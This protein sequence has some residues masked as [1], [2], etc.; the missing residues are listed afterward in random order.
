MMTDLTSYGV[1]DLLNGYKNGDFSPVEVTKSYLDRIDK[2]ND[3]LN[4]FVLVNKDEAIKQAQDAEAAYNSRTSTPS[5]LGIPL[6]HKDLY[7]TAN[8]RSTAGSRVLKDHVPT[9]D[10]TSIALLTSHGAINLG[11]LN[12]H[13][14]AYGPTN[15]QSM[16]G[17]CLNP[18]NTEYF[19]GGSSGGSGAAVAASLCLGATGS[20][21]G[22]SIRIPS[23]CCG[24]TGLKPTYG[25]IS[26][27]GIVPLCW[28]MDHSGPMTRSAKDAALMLQAMAGFDPKDSAS[29]QTVVPDYINSLSG[30]IKGK[31]IGLPNRYFFDQAD[32]SIE[33]SVMQALSVLEGLG[34][35]L[36][37]IDIKYIEHA[38]AAALAIYL[39]EGTAFHDHGFN[40][41]QS[42]YTDQVRGFLELGNFIL[43]KDYIHAQRFRTLL[44]QEMANLLDEVD[45]FATPGLSLTAQKIGQ[46][47]IT[48]RGVDQ[49]VFSAILRNTE[50]FNLTGLPA[51]VMPC[52]FSN[53]GMPQSLQIVGRPFD[54]AGILNVAHAYQEASDWHLKKP[55]L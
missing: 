4:A 11:K 37:P 17:S 50:P 15:E 28:T 24:I 20:D 32:E 31:K 5:L 52:G 13:E 51:I 27:S 29:S 10:A 30:D 33:E 16:F 1:L 40:L 42:L 8:I 26:R 23:A 21:T 47:D 44:G 9:E 41:N 53:D 25:R 22:G 46:E 3:T 7:S 39:S 45:Y 36:V 54:E 19:S 43:A 49:T 55:I 6:A 34:A 14:F 48:I 12:T 2:Y 18:W 38:A 35:I